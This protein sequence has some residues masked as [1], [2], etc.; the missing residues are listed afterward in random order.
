MGL[1]DTKEHIPTKR[2]ASL[3]GKAAVNT[4]GH[5]WILRELVGQLKGPAKLPELHNA[6]QML[7]QDVEDMPFVFARVFPDG[8]ARPDMRRVQLASGGKEL[9]ASTRVLMNAN[10]EQGIAVEDDAAL[11]SHLNEPS[12]LRLI[13]RRYAERQ[14]Y[15]RAGPVLV[16]M[17]PFESMEADMY[18]PNMLAK[19]QGQQ[20]AGVV[21][22]PPH[23]YEVA[24][25][26]YEALR[27]KVRGKEGPQSI[28]INGESGSG[29][30]ETTKIIL[31]F[32]THQSGGDEI[33]RKLH[34]APRGARWHPLATH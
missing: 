16:A 13:Q 7:E 8:S 1:G 4:T 3:L 34:R 18:G 14:I 28:V 33:S 25:A 20:R 15:T 2:K 23:V 5:V 22:P 27:G 6:L 31:R 24:S 11:I 19:Y 26:A 21:R 17:N 30:T 12:L 32:L 10:P 9:P 29:K